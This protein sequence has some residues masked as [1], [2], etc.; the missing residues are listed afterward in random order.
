MLTA[1]VFKGS[2]GALLGKPGDLVNNLSSVP[3]QK[4]MCN[5]SSAVLDP[6]AMALYSVVSFEFYGYDNPTTI[7]TKV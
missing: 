6:T 7:A 4:D 2:D 5:T 3:V 1:S